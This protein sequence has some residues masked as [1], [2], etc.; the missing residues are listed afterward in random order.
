MFDQTDSVEWYAIF[1]KDLRV[2]P[3]RMKPTGWPRSQITEEN[4]NRASRLLFRK[5]QY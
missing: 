5:S 2:V 4:I 3:V 1:V